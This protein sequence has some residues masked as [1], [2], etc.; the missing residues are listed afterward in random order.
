MEILR[1]S[2]S[3]SPRLKAFFER[4]VLPGAIDFSL[5]RHGSFFDQYRLFSD[6]HETLMMVDDDLEIAGM[7]S[8][9]FREGNING[10]KQIWAFATDLRI[11]PT[12][13]AISQWAQKF[14]PELEAACEQRRCKFVFSAVHTSDNQAYNALIRPTSHT[15]RRLP[16]YHLMNR[17]R[18]IGIHGRVPF[19]EKP[20]QSIRLTEMRHGDLEPL[21]AYLVESD[22][23][24][25]LSG[26]PTPQNFLEELGRWPGL[27]L[28]DFRIARDSKGKILG[29]AALWDGRRT[30][31]WVPQSYN[32]IAATL[33]QSL[34]LGSLFRVTRPLAD[35][36]EPLA[37]K[38]LTHLHCDTPEVFHRLADE[39]YSRVERPEFLAYLHF[40]GNWRTLP[41]LSFIT[42]SLPYGFYM[43][44][45]PNLD[46]PDLRLRTP[47]TTRMDQLPPEFEM[48]WL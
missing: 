26:L 36:G 10:E 25:F 37:M 28:P 48:A 2:E 3:D 18:V 41:P 46:V 38:Y 11:A 24:R 42:T 15:R 1:A 47:G 39:A 9:L 43:V 40:R 19:S 7:A 44:L 12:R 27:R 22:K 23:R 21:C 4:M 33:H 8:V 13:K 35:P 14:L 31:T 6:D 16:R 30:Q 17:F 32:G 29:C 5:H 20:L 45:P 34:S